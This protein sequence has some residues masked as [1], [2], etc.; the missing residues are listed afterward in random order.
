MRWARWARGGGA[1]LPARPSPG[2][3]SVEW[4]SAVR[5]T[6]A[7]TITYTPL[8]LFPNTVAVE[9]A[10]V[11]KRHQRLEFPVP[12]LPSRFSATVSFSAVSRSLI[13][14]FPSHQTQTINDRDWRTI[15][16][17]CLWVFGIGPQVRGR[18][19]GGADCG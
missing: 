8:S 6:W 5:R 19:R 10:K 9:Y 11:N 13:P 2:P 4:K 7:I 18:G 12:D 16:A 14:R 1:R 15:L 3:Q 17:R